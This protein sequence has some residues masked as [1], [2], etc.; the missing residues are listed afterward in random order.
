[1]IIAHRGASAFAPENTIAAISKALSLGAGGIEIDVQMGKGGDLFLFHDW[2][3]ERIGGMNLL[4][5]EMKTSDIRKI[6]AG[7]WFSE[8]YRG[9]KIPYLSEALN[10]IPKN[11]GMLVN[12]ELKKTAA[13]TRDVETMLV[14][15]VRDMGMAEDTI[16]S[17]F[18]YKSI[19]KIQSI[20]P[21][22]KTALITYGSFPDPMRYFSIFR[23]Y[24][25]HPAFYYTDREFVETMHSNNLRVY[26][27]VVDEP[28]YARAL[29]EIG[30]DGIITNRPGFVF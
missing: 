16:I 22:V 8:E 21:G 25:I 4:F 12:I 3:T 14:K 17:S 28:E 29:T 15:M 26:P 23:C 20:D 9:E 19:A 6:D 10:L 18:N 11:R 5:S 7:S 1:M 2:T 30:C 24:S 13:D 27:W